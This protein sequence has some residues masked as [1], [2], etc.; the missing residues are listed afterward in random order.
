VTTGN[1]PLSGDAA[2]PAEGS[3]L[4][5][6]VD[7]E[8]VRWLWQARIPLGKLT[9][10][11][12]DP[13][14][15]K[16]TLV[17]DLAA[18][19]SSAGAWPDGQQGGGDVGRV[20]LLSAE[21]DAAD[22]IVP[23]LSAA[24][25]VLANIA[26]WDKAVLWDEDGER[27][28]PIVFPDHLP[29]LARQVRAFGCQLVIVDVL[30]AYLSVQVDSHKDQSVRVLLARMS[31]LAAATGAAI[32]LVRHL[33]KGGSGPA[34]YRG[35]GSIGIIGAA[36]AGYQVIADGDDP[37][38]RLFTCVKNNLAPRAPTLAY[39]LEPAPGT[40][41]ARV[42][43][44]ERPDPRSADELHATNAAAPNKSAAASE[45]LELYG[46]THGWEARSAEVIRDAAENGISR[47]TLYR[48]TEHVGI[49]RSG[50]GGP[51]LWTWP[52]PD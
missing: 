14:V 20:L 26:V 49:Q 27:T 11:E 34:I 41:V 47:R 19:Y 23:R 36:R 8:P 48:A 28:V 15:G 9:V 35:G 1:F 46:A 7:P 33:N 45:W 18:R 24:G 42:A 16:S 6:D 4:L 51:G 10:V 32:I 39:R 22:T 52:Q 17:Y 50:R 31:E 13:A 29:L 5:A 21:D 38:R 30:M 12:G 37:G 25:A 3:R 40:D 2:C 44:D 43:W